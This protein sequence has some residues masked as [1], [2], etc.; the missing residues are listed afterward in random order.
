MGIWSIYP[1]SSRDIRNVDKLAATWA[2]RWVT[3]IGPCGMDWT[4]ELEIYSRNWALV[5]ES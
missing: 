2:G 5:L 3:L 1:D 4:V